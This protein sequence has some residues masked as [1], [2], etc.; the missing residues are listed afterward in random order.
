MTKQ[1]F[2]TTFDLALYAA[3]ACISIVG[4]FSSSS[5]SEMMVRTIG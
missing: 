3:L 1:S 2:A 4:M 5:A